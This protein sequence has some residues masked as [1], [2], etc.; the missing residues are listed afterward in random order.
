MAIVRYFEDLECWQEA[1]QLVKLIFLSCEL[2]KLARDHETSQELKKAALSLIS[3]I[4]DSCM[5]K[6]P[7]EGIKM[8]DAA[9]SSLM[10]I[11]NITY[12]VDDLE[13]IPIRYVEAI[14][15]K[16]ERVGISIRDLRRRIENRDKLSDTS[17]NE[18]L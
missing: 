6:D 16:S 14:Q 1:R 8:I 2:G 11:R 12:I 18:V 7:R 10:D 13:Y 3:R 5:Q 9:R 17:K 15:Q 4:A